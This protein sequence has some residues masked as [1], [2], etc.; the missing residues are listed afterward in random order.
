METLLLNINAVFDIKIQEQ[1]HHA[2]YLGT[3]KK[4]QQQQKTNDFNP[5]QAITGT[6]H[7]KSQSTWHKTK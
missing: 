2:H 7:A 5:E 3:E 6:R 1:R 4:K